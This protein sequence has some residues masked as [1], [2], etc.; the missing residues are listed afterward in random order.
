MCTDAEFGEYG[1][2]EDVIEE[3]DVELLHAIAQ[4]GVSQTHL[5]LAQPLP[6][7]LQ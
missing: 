5:S 3:Q 6:V 7:G 2:H 1:R 4:V